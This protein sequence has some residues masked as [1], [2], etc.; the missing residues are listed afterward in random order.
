MNKCQASVLYAAGDTELP[1]LEYGPCPL[2]DPAGEASVQLVMKGL[3]LHPQ[4]HPGSCYLEAFL[5]PAG[6]VAISFAI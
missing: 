6:K 2:R 1:C 4:H 5:A 3:G